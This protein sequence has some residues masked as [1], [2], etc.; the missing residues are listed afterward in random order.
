MDE[1]YDSG[2]GSSGRLA[3]GFTVGDGHFRR[4]VMALRE[5]ILLQDAEGRV[6]EC[7]PAAERIL[8]MSR[9][10]LVGVPTAQLPL[11][12]IHPD[13]S[14]FPEA[15]RR[16]AF[17]RE[18]HPT[19]LPPQSGHASREVVMGVRTAGAGI[20]WAIVHSA[21]LNRPGEPEPYAVV[22]SFTDIT[23]L[24]RA[25]EELE[26]SEER[27]RLAFEEAL[28]GMTLMGVDPDRP[29]R[30]L[31][32][33]RAFCE[34][35]GYPREW[36]T[37]RT[38]EDIT[39]PE[40]LPAARAAVARFVAGGQSSYRAQRRYRHASG[41]TVWAAFSIAMVRDR[42]GRPVYAV[43]MFEDITARKQAEQDLVY[44]ALHDDLTGLPNRSLLLDHLEGSLARARRSGSAVGV[45]FLDL[46]DFKAINDSYG[47]PVGDEFLR[48]VAERVVSCL[49][50][51]DT[52]ARIGGDEFVVVCEGLTDPAEAGVI[53]DRIQQALGTEIHLLG[54]SVAA[55]VSIGIAVSD[56][57]STPETLLRDADTAMYVAKRSGGRR[58]EPANETLHA[59]AVR[60]MTVDHELR[61]ALAAEQLRVHYQPIFA[62]DGQLPV[63]VEALLR[64]EHPQRGMVEPGE[65]L[66]V[67]EQ[68]GLIGPLGELVLEQACR[69][70]SAW[71]ERYGEAAPAVCVNVSSRQLGRGGL[72][73][74][75]QG[76][77]EAHR[78]PADR[79]CLEITETQLLAIGAS[80]VGDLDTLAGAGVRLAVDDFGTGFAGFQYLRRLP[81]H[82]L[83]IDLS[84][85]AGLDVD[86]TDTAIVTSMIALGRSLGLTVVAE[87]IET[88]EQLRAL[89]ELGCGWGQGWLWSPAVPAEQ[90][91]CLLDQLRRS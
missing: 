75:V 1:A 76:L 4:V 14:P 35:L 28:S 8:G 78:L 2:A 72:S 47:H 37:G 45:L 81:V 15:L 5:G 41:G 36:L 16:I 65:F 34:F 60:V 39:I 84:F 3:E 69:Q 20:R 24:Q 52:A 80:G 79:L 6:V 49:R 62:L 88:P 70:A 50:G 29:G 23:E 33:N 12:V 74:T 42:H 32:V 58:W 91:A 7:N 26:D 11:T 87:G 83:K 85:V 56:A 10:E 73:R 90:I 21:P 67:A 89:T 22:A 71:R 68:R 54:Q 82:E 77:L 66:D 38:F 31:R 61:R 25:R 30:F 40:D 86:P 46:D 19:P 44:R 43:G 55:P 13:G 63:A 48:K 53:A 17:P 59:A 51:E 27:F 57:A 64:W 18:A 9:T